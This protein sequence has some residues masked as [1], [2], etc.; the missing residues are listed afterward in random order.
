MA[1]SLTSTS[2]F[3]SVYQDTL[4]AGWNN[5]SWATTNLASSSPV[6]SGSAA[7]AVTYG[8]WTGL[9]FAGASLPASGLDF[10]DL[11]VNGGA[12]AAPKISARLGLGAS[13]GPVVSIGQYCQGNAIPASTFARCQ[14]PLSA[15]GATS[16]S[17][18]TALVLQEGAGKALKPMYYDAVG[19]SAA[20]PLPPAA[21]PATP[22]GL[23]ATA[24]PTSVSLSWLAA[25]GASSY[26]V[27]RGAAQGGP[28]AALSVAQLAT[29]YT[30]PTAFAGASYWYTVAAQNAAGSSS[31]AAPVKATVPLPPPPPSGAFSFNE[32]FAWSG[33]HA[34]TVSAGGTTT[35]WN[36]DYWDVRGDTSY[37]AA[38]YLSTQVQ[39]AKGF[40]VDIH[41]AASADATSSVIDNTVHIPGGDGSRGLGTM[42]LDFEGIVS[43]RL[44]NPLLIASEARPGIVTFR[45]TR[46]VTTGHWWEVAIT[47]A[48]RVTAG[49]WTSVPAADAGLAGPLG[50]GVE[51]NTSS[52]VG[53]GHTPPEDSVNFIFQGYPDLPCQYGWHV[54][55]EVKATIAGKQT[56]VWT[57]VGAYA[58]L[59]PTDPAEKDHLYSYRLEYRPS[60][61]DF[62]ADWD[63]PGVLTLRGHYPLSIPWS[64]V[65]VQLLGVAY[66]ADHHPQA[67]CYQGQVRELHWTDLSASPVKYA[68]TSVAPRDGVTTNVSRNSGF[69]GYDLRDIQRYGG[70]ASD[71]LLLPNSVPYDLYGSMAYASFQVWAGAGAPAPVQAIDLSVD[72]TSAQASAA[73]AQLLYDIRYTGTATLSI[74]GT[75]VGTLPKASTVP[76]AVA[77]SSN[78]STIWVRRGLPFSP[79]LLHAGANSIHLALS[80]QVGL[81]RLQLEFSHTH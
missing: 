11:Q 56:N 32:P 9:Y 3:V 54:H 60:G 67:P 7:I 27:F 81:D 49:E 23:I 26:S 77:E 13:F 12:N 58:E 44:R 59:P 48:S 24:S 50:T 46:F 33:S 40:H 2:T 4:S 72:L 71:G 64:E 61:V 8:A 76:A 6:S 43:A 45:Q 36:A 75:V 19:F 5:W 42:R 65:N 68:S 20:A 25:S 69:M 52:G 63:V 80:G 18:I 55:P 38:G 41:K 73:T 74:N 22:T 47:P 14:V 10:L 1:F 29:A 15:L 39:Q 70:P 78:L 35:W 57:P 21:P 62:Y 28:F 34:A 16:A 79:G 53:N 37:N 31:Q 51:I 66:Q 17:T 30:D